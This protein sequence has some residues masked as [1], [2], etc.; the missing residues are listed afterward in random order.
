MGYSDMQKNLNLT[1]S[2]SVTTEKNIVYNWLRLHKICWIAINVHVRTCNFDSQCKRILQ[3]THGSLDVG[4]CSQSL[5]N[6]NSMFTYNANEFCKDYMDYLMFAHNLRSI[7][8]VCRFIVQVTTRP[9]LIIFIIQIVR[10][11][12]N[13]VWITYVG[14]RDLGIWV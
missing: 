14:I 10:R 8:L 7:H 12:V 2:R 11:A 6:L 3:V 5:F 13:W 1:I 9:S 4:I